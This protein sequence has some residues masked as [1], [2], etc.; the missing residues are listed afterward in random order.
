MR[1]LYDKQYNCY[2][3]KPSNSLNQR[4]EAMNGEIKTESK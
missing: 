4:Y 3:T 1:E 2:D